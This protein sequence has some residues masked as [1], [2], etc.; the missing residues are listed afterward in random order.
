MSPE[1]QPVAV[2]YYCH[3]SPSVSRDQYTALPLE[4]VLVARYE[5]K[6]YIYT[7]WYK[8]ETVICQFLE[9]LGIVQLLGFSGFSLYPLSCSLY[10]PSSKLEA[11]VTRKKI[12]THSVIIKLEHHTAFERFFNFF[13]IY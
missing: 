5:R 2:Q 8:F 10:I 12:K 1:L 13:K 6:F 4:G 11:T 9:T 7:F 3:G